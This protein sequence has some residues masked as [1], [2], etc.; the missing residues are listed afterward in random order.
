MF[1]WMKLFLA[2][3]YLNIYYICFKILFISKLDGD[4]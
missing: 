3:V 2:F 4:E 1:V